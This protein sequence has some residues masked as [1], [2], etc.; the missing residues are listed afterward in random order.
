M[1]V[2]VVTDENFESTVK[3]NDKVVVKYYA[4]WCGT[5][6]LLA[7][8]YKRLSED[9]RFKEITFLDVDAEKSPA[10]RKVAGVDNLPTIAVFKDGELIDKV[11]SGK[12]DALVELLNKL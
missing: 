11:C 8:K 6:R 3:N 10:S 1:A 12:E 2:T 4:G 7:P 5:C 9:E